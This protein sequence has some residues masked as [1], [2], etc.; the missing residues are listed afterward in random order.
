MPE[1]TFVSALPKVLVFTKV[2]GRISPRID[3]L[4]LGGLRHTERQES[5]LKG[6]FHKTQKLPHPAYFFAP[7]SVI[8]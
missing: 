8:I 6:E 2:N 5:R 1:F 3:V 4:P 7:H